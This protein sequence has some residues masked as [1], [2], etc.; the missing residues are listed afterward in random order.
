MSP[1]FESST[2][3]PLVRF[4]AGAFGGETAGEGLG[5]LALYV[6]YYHFVRPH[7]SLRVQLPSPIPTQGRVLRKWE[8]RT[9]AMAAGITQRVWSLRALLVFRVTITATY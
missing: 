6:A 5:D 9:P 3:V 8:R 2:N 1:L 4:D 7:S